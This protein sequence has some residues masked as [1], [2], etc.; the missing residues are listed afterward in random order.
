MIQY[1]GNNLNKHGFT[2]TAMEI[3][4]PHLEKRYELVSAS[5]LKNPIY[6]MLHMIRVFFKYRKQTKLVLID[7]YSTNAFYYA[8][9]IGIIIIL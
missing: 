4:I 9:I 8:L 3:L 1:F 7:T 6:R 5:S 2:P